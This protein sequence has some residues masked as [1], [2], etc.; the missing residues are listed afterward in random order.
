MYNEQCTIFRQPI[1]GQ[2]T[3][4]IINCKLYIVNDL[5][6]ILNIKKNVTF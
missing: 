6:F 5:F 2:D 4:Y 3:L 1:S